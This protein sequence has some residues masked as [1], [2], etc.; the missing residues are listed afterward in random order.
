MEIAVD[1]RLASPSSDRFRIQ[2]ALQIKLLSILG[3]LRQPGQIRNQ[4]YTLNRKF[5]STPHVVF[6]REFILTIIFRVFYYNSGTSY[7]NLS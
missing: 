1:P 3:C 4:P 5:K 2:V 7:P 6:V